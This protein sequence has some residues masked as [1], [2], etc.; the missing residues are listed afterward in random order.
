MHTVELDVDTAEGVTGFATR[1]LAEHP[2]PNVLVNNAGVMRFEALD[3][4]RNLLDAEQTININLLCP[5]RLIDALVGQPGAAVVNVTS[6][7]TFVPLVARRPTTPPRR[8]CTP[9]RLP[10]GK[11]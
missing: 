2:A 7:L 11:C 5:I 10:C 4:P 8:P 3:R 9:T 1:L 6:E